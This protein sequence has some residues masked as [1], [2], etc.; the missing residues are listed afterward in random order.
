MCIRPQCR[1]LLVV[2]M[3]AGLPAAICD[4]FPAQKWVY[5]PF[6]GRPSTGSPSVD[7][8]CAS[9]CRGYRDQPW[10]SLHTK[11]NKQTNKNK[12][13]FD[14]DNI[15]YMCPVCTKQIYFK[16]QIGLECHHISH[17]TLSSQCV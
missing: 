13:T 6:Y 8:G 1:S 7:G 16:S 17:T 10:S 14:T 9:P 15:S 12:H 5:L 11:A 4:F 3:P 2:G